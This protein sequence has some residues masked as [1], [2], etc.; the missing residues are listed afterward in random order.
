MNKKLIFVLIAASLVLIAGC[1]GGKKEDERPITD[2]DIRKGIDGL[3]MEFTSNAPP[4]SVFEN[5]PFPIAAELRN[6][7]AFDIGDKIGDFDGK[8]GT[9]V[10]GF[11][12]T[13]V[14]IGDLVAV[15]RFKNLFPDELDEFRLSLNES[16][17]EHLEDLL[18]KR[19][20]VF[21]GAEMDAVIDFSSSYV[22]KLF[23][24]DLENLT[25]DEVN[26]LHIEGVVSLIHMDKLKDD[27]ILRADE[28]K[29][30]AVVEDL[31]TYF[32]TVS[33]NIDE[34][35]V[36]RDGLKSSL[37]TDLTTLLIKDPGDLTDGEEAAIGVFSDEYLDKL[38][39]NILRELSD[40]DLGTL[41]IEGM[42]NSIT[43]ELTDAIKDLDEEAKKSAVVED[44]KTYFGSVS[45]NI[46]EVNV[47][48][49]NELKVELISDL[50]ELL[51][52]PGSTLS[53][54]EDDA[55][56]VFSDE[57]L[58]KLF[59]NI[60]R[61]L[62]DEDLGTLPIE[63]LIGS[64]DE[65]RLNDAIKDLAD[66]V[67]MSVVD[68]DIKAYWPEF[69]K[70]AKGIL[71]RK[72][73]EIK[74][75]SIFNPEGDVEYIIIDAETKKISA[76]SETHPSTIFATA[77]YPYKTIFGSSVCIDPDIYGMGKGQKACDIKE[78]AFPQGQGAPV[79][80]T[81][82]ETRMLPEIGEDKVRPH[83]FI[84]IENKGN[85]EVVNLSKVE[86][87]CTNE[88]LEYTDFNSMQINVTLSGKLLDCSV[89]TGGAKI[90]TIR[91]RDKKDLVRCTL[92]EGIDLGRDAYTAPLRIELQYGYTFTI[93]KDIIIEKI[94]KY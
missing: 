2:V 32:G 42:M 76:Q 89:D 91:L 74:G 83:F 46:D 11:Q 17:I 87:A 75:K 64:I 28:A 14:D 27:I 35:N 94:L 93:S 58:D 12:R 26:N 38:F 33:S 37:T 30:S 5:S 53:S 45:S 1:S 34:V 22:E 52:A 25:V 48:R 23:E 36:I 3:D 29:K 80:V 20:E 43:S 63:G 71:A 54:D 82:I 50:K 56:D 44:L 67:K 31:K 10:F 66:V 86:K 78:M 7:G 49:D 18:I 92:E 72:K 62:S 55:I 57:Y 60:L 21:K 41:A 39:E 69:I 85:G 47:I 24:K 81:K 84:F 61:E 15:E 65:N 16:L 77:C 40:E 9:I 73:F 8:N 68:A 19:D 79:A 6:K 70:I 13:Y 59:E 90:E 4:P 51:I 88:P